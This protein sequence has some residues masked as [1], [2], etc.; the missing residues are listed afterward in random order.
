MI[1]NIFIYEGWV[2]IDRDGKHFGKI[3]NYLRDR[4]PVL[5]DSYE[6]CKELMME[7]KYFLIEDL[8]KICEDTLKHLEGKN[9]HYLPICRVPIITSI[10]EEQRI[11]SAAN[12]VGCRT[13]HYWGRIMSYL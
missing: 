13:F 12:K 1:L 3:L 5:T 9:R 11:V 8:T 2:L 7:A 4:T 10:R 6:E